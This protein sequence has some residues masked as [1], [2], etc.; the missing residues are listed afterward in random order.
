MKLASHIVR[1]RLNCFPL[2]ALLMLVVIVATPAN[3]QFR[4]LHSFKAGR[5]G[6]Y[7]NPSLVIDKT[8]N[9]FG[10]AYS[11]GAHGAGTVYELSP[12]SGRYTFQNIY[13]FC[14]QPSCT[15]GARPY[16]S[17]VVLD[18]VG[19]LYGT[20]SLGGALSGLG[21]V[22]ELTPS[23][24]G[25]S[26]TILHA[27]TGGIDGDSPYA[28]VVL[29][30]A[31]N[32]YGVTTSLLS[33]NFVGTV[34]ELSPSG[35][36]WTET[37]LHNFRTNGWDGE[38]PGL[39]AGLTLH[40]GSLFGTTSL[41]GNIGRG[42]VFQFSPLPGGGWSERVLFDTG[43]P[44][45]VDS[46]GNIYAV[47]SSGAFGA[48]TVFQ[49]IP[50]P[51]GWT[52]SPVYDFKG[53]LDGAGPY[54]VIADAAGNLFGVTNVGGNPGCAVREGCGTVFELSLSNG[55]WTKTTLYSFQ[56]TDDGGN[57]TG[58]LAIDQKG[59]LFGVTQEGG[60]NKVGVTYEI[61]R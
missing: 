53:G 56:G 8:G 38:Y 16:F 52:T 54:P 55:V 14:A 44:F 40:G 17:G 2:P 58:P 32:V 20:T 39:E 19:N 3:A 41:G 51:E 18:S 33:F 59:N 57:P 23:N 36:I 12:K 1:M 35:G 45:T 46:A 25:W 21:T 9:I 34:F 60:A 50:S 48:G 37:I 11:F 28:G 24:G 49:F 27:F 6:A 22:F 47:S 43:Y 31:G 13:D 29:D 15:D 42:A 26:E 30:K 4:V 61:V 7:P 10:T 5:D